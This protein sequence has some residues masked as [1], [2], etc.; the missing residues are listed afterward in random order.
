M[1]ETLEVSQMLANSYEPKRAFRWYLSID[2]I[3]A[4]TAKT[5]G[6]PNEK[7]EETV[8]DYINQ[9]SYF[10][11][12]REWE[13]IDISLYDPIS[14]SA[15]QK[16]FQWLQLVSSAETGRMGYKDFYTKTVTLKLLDPGGT[17][18]EQWTG[19]NVWPSN[20]KFNATELDYSKSDALTVSLTLRADIW[21]LNF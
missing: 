10:A 11:G 1:A 20:V 5:A 16:V 9:K 19:K 8:I 13:T 21:S 7:H 2:G 18:V 14:P 6:R 4:F 3:D 12:K 17:V 15:A